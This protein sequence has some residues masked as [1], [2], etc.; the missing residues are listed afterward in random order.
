MTQLVS[1]LVTQNQVEADVYRFWLNEMKETNRYTRKQWEWVFILQ[2]L[3]QHGLLHPGRRGVGFGVGKEPIPAL[4]AKNG[5]TVLATELNIERPSKDGWVKGRNL[6]QQ[7]QA[8]NDKGICEADQF[9]SLVSHRDVD[10]NHIPDNIQD[11]D[12]TWSSCALE[13]LGSLKHG[14]DFIINSL[15]C[16]KPGGLAVHTTEFTFSRKITVQKGSSVYYRKSDIISLAE[17]LAVKGHELTLN[18]SKGKR[19]LDWY[20]DIPPYRNHRHLKLLVSKQSKLL[21][22]TSIGLIV[23]KNSH[24]ET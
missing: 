3:K 2:A 7:L 23:K 16:L 18:F 17:E 5:C 22:A 19:F 8:L 9:E 6:K 12:F 4:L 11:F 10:M 24:P 1:Q 20:I 13:H 15:R 21:I 14:A